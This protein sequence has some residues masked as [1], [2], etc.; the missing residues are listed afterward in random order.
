[1]VDLNTVK[2]AFITYFG[3][4]E[5]LDALGGD[6]AIRL[7]VDFTRSIRRGPVATTGLILDRWQQYKPTGWTVFNPDR[8]RLRKRAENWKNWEQCRGVDRLDLVPQYR[9]AYTDG[10][11]TPLSFGGRDYIVS[12]SGA[13]LTEGYG[14]CMGIEECEAKAVSLILDRVHIKQNLVLLLDNDTVVKLL[15]GLLEVNAAIGPDAG[16]EIYDMLTK[17]DD[18]EGKIVVHWIP[19]HSDVPGN[20][21]ADYL[22]EISLTAARAKLLDPAVPTSFKDRFLAPSARSP[23]PHGWKPPLF[24]PARLL[25]GPSA[26]I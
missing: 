23:P 26:P 14:G 22:A 6:D 21:T 11:Q 20:E 13:Y 24:P 10:G 3:D 2:T 8:R 25:R 1:I 4:T 5:A 19:G 16:R 17:A 15:T 9:F 12:S 18:H 7:L